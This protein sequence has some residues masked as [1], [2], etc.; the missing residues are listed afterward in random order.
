MSSASI[1][2]LDYES[3]SLVVIVFFLVGGCVKL[4]MECFRILDRMHERGSRLSPEAV[5]MGT[6]ESGGNGGD[7]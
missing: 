4:G 5:E 3:L 2:S 6:L 7:A 1:A